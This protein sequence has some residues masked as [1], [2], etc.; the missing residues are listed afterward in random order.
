MLWAGRSRAIYFGLLA[1]ENGKVLVVEP[2]QEN[3]RELR[4][5]VSKQG[6]TNIILALRAAWSAQKTLKMRINSRHPAANFIEGTK[7]LTADHLAEFRQVNIP[8]D[9]LDNI[10]DANNIEH[11]DLV[12]ITTN[13]SEHE[14][15]KGMVKAIARGIPY[16]SLAYTDNYIELMQAI[17]YEMHTYDDRGITFRQSRILGMDELKRV[18]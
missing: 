2:D 1:K 9:T 5:I 15:I 4:Q 18:L 7:T 10:L 12:S 11:L 14:I 3:I 13:G 8:A 17:G 16:I 6:L